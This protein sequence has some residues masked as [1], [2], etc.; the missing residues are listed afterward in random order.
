MRY[1][2]INVGQTLKKGNSLMVFIEVLA[3]VF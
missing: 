2:S 3:L 1:F